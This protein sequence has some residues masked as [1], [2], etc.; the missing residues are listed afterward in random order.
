MTY[1]E[2][3]NAVREAEAVVRRAELY[4]SRM[5]RFLIG[6]LRG[7]DSDILRDLKKELRKFNASTGEWDSK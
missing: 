5:A 4:K 7:I 6:R 3:D 1:Q 2:M